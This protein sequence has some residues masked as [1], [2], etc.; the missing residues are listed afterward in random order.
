MMELL[1]REPEL[2]RIGAVLAARGASSPVLVI[3]GEPGIGKTSIWLAAVAQ[4]SALAWRVLAA[5]PTEVEATFAYASLGDL[6]ASVLDDDLASLPA[7]QRRALRVALLRDEPVGPPP[8]A[9]AI[10]VAF[11]NLLT[12]LAKDRPLLVAVDDI[13]WLDPASALALGF[14]IRRIGDNPVRFLLAH[15]VEEGADAPQVLDR[16]LADVS[17]ERIP[18]GPL[19]PEVLHRLLG[20]RFGPA[21]DHATVRAIHATSGGNPLFAI[22]IGRAMQ[23]RS[24]SLDIGEEPPIPDDLM[25]LVTARVASL[26]D[27]TQ[28]ALAVA[29][30]LAS[31]TVE[32]IS[33]ATGWAAERALGPALDAHLV[34]LDGERVRFTHPLRAAAVR[35]RT[36]PV[37]RREIHAR[38]AELITDPEERARHLAIATTEPDEGVAMALEDAAQRARARGAPHAAA[39]LAAEARRLTPADRPTDARRRSVAEATYLW[40]AGD[41]LPAQALAAEIL[42]TC[43][44]GPAR[45]SALFQLA[46]TANFSMVSWSGPNRVTLLQQAIAEASGDDRLRMRLEGVLTGALDLQGNDVRGALAHGYAE[47]ELGERL[48]D[49]VHIAT[50]L[51]GIARNEQRLTG[52]MP[53]EL[54]D[55]SMALEPAVSAARY[56]LE[57]PSVCLAEMLSWTDDLAAGVERWEWLLTQ[58][59]ERGET[60]SRI[61][62]L[63]RAIPY[64]C[65]AGWWD[66][67]LAHADEGCELGRD[68]N[69][70]HLLAPVLV[71][72]RALVEA[73]LGHEAAARRD[74]CEAMLLE[75][76][77]GTILA[78]RIA[79]WALGLLELSLREPARALAHLGPLVVSRRAA[80]VIEPGDMRVVTD[81]VEA[82]I[83]VGRLAEAEAMLE[84]YEGLA[85][86]SGR[87]GALAACGRC[88]GLLHAA[89]GDLDP[90]VTALEISRD[91]YATVTEPFG[92]GR[93]LL[94]LGTIERR[95]VRRR[96]AREALEASLGVFDGLGARIW[97]ERARAEL[98]RIGGRRAVGTELTLS[99]QQVAVLVAKGRTNREVAA[100][101]VL[102]E[103][104]IEGHLSHVYA[105]LGIRSRAELARRLA[106]EAGGR[107]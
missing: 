70:V 103:R 2:A 22:E 4:A 107:R 17:H 29:A 19:S 14:A 1:G 41:F 82:L 73:H 90:A 35:S 42:A 9:R 50:A 48:H 86:Q 92:L 89:R 31:P 8:E 34:A 46:G 32:L 84:W 95:R 97:V 98:A 26:P 59:A 13:Q 58:A 24:A 93:T 61:D 7:P 102:T 75:R 21:C 67:A 96:A 69:P 65:V 43:P 94:A 55:R 71:A 100:A 38:L 57:W 87:I 63:A 12:V 16:A 56:V 62:T 77:S 45:S 5:R 30:A 54:I 105:K 104:T 20:A 15:R 99:E 6:L 10:A 51:R 72:D 11:L 25:A 78:G 23:A 64:E 28:D 60:N 49:E 36:L 27:E 40:V 47:L 83:G 106:P 37:R 88:R 80:G 81:T 74:A 76:A 101:L 68:G 39:E 18:V 3:D 66:R 52:R 91:R 79:A 33:R 53:T 44:P 85:R